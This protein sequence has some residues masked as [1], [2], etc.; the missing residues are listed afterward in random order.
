MRNGFESASECRTF[1]SVSRTSNE[2]NVIFSKKSVFLRL[3][4]FFL[5]KDVFWY[6]KW[7]FI[8]IKSRINY[9]FHKSKFVCFDEEAKFELKYLMLSFVT[10]HFEIYTEI[11]ILIKILAGK[12]Y[13]YG[14]KKPL[15]NRID[16]SDRPKFWLLRQLTPAEPAIQKNQSNFWSS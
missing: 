5:L 12:V 7:Y 9:Y 2:K 13:R 1:E 11:L 3:K 16:E 10:A 4:N 6:Y 15:E 14:I 8:F